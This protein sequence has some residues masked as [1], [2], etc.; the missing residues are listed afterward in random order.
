MTSIL[1]GYVNYQY[2]VMVVD[3]LVKQYGEAYPHLSG[4]EIA[5]LLP[6]KH[7]DRKGIYKG[8]LSPI[9]NHGAIIKEV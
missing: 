5:V 3:A 7:I 8:L 1:P 9:P 4:Y 6:Q 2:G